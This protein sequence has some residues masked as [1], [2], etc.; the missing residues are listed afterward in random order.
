LQ[1]S[2]AGSGTLELSAIDL[3]DIINDV[4]LLFRQEIMQTN[5]EIHFKNLP[6]I[7]ASRT[8]MLQLFQNLLSNALKYKSSAKPVITIN[9][10]ETGQ[11]WIIRF[12]DNG[13]GIAPEYFNKIFIIFQRL[14]RKE[15]FSGTGIGLSICKKIVER[16][17]GNIRVE[18]ELGKGSSF[19]ITLPKD[20]GQSPEL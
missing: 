20:I 6:V 1:Y 17:N 2:R 15:E 16:F 18:S 14:H 11:E 7:K 19:I 12:I 13:I 8:A 10:I 4:L 5:A 9:C 3:N